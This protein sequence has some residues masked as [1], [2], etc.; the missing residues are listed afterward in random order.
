MEEALEIA[1][2]T[3]VLRIS[4][5]SIKN[6]IIIPSNVRYVYWNSVI[7]PFPEIPTSVTHLNCANSFI[8]ELPQLHDRLFYL[9][10]SYSGI[11]KL[12]KLPSNLRY[13]DCSSSGISK[14]PKLP[15][16][17]L[18]LYCGDNAISLLPELP[19]TLLTLFCRNTLITYLPELPP[20]MEIID[21]S[22][23][24]CLA[25]LSLASPK[26]VFRFNNTPLISLE[27]IMDEAPAAC[28]ERMAQW[29]EKESGNRMKKRTII[30]KEELVE[31]VWIDG[32]TA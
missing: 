4:D 3:G 32:S 12:P 10:C 11:S 25:Y 6:R 29:L 28:F 27:K 23:S 19:K 20:T 1:K 7:G 18:S 22:E 16:N 9:D 24:P 2:N 17:L 21:V 30:I 15:F 31:K 13:L 5:I 26:T 14:L 8:G